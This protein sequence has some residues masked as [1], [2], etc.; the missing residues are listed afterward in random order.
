MADT[1]TISKQQYKELIEKA[2]MFESIA[3]EE[4]LTAA[5]LRKLRRAE[6]SKTL[7]EKEAR[8]KYQSFFK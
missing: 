5:E 3:D 7:T 6:K 8:A 2:K 4:G 1:I